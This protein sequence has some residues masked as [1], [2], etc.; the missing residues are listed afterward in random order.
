V[1]RVY[2]GPCCTASDRARE[3]VEWVRE[4]RPEAN[5]DVIEI[6]DLDEG[7]DSLFA[8]PTWYWNADVWRLGNP[9]PSELL[10]AVDEDALNRCG[11]ACD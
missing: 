11:S 4:S 9:S 8:L 2:A 6:E 10:T 7:P 3:L 1:I 5:I